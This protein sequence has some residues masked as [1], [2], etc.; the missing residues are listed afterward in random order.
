MHSLP[1]PP[2]VLHRGREVVVDPHRG[3]GGEGGEHQAVEEAGQGGGEGAHPGEASHVHPVRGMVR[4]LLGGHRE[5]PDHRGP[6]SELRL[7]GSALLNTKG[8]GVVVKSS[9]AECGDP[10]T[11]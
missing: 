1:P 11:D 4:G 8:R 6:G 3:P 10:V 2:L 7:G 9:G 5:V